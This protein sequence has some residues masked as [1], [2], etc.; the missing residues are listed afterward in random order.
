MKPVGD[1]SGEEGET[2]IEKIGMGNPIYDK[3]KESEM[4]KPREKEEQIRGGNW[5][6]KRGLQEHNYGMGNP[7]Y[8]EPETERRVEKET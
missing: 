8:D 4:R 2:S 6:Q 5:R 1:G 3:P 7:I